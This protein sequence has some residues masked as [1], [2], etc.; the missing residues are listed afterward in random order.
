MKTL[1]TFL[2]QKGLYYRK[3]G[4]YE[5]MIVYWIRLSWRSFPH[6]VAF[7]LKRVN[8]NGLVA[9][10]HHY[11][12]AVVQSQRLLKDL[13]ASLGYNSAFAYKKLYDHHNGRVIGH[14]TPYL[15]KR[16]K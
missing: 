14:F 3:G 11:G 9:E 10:I 15:T 5:N 2:T 1:E 12:K 7:V 8:E 16:G 13:L 6:D 4:E